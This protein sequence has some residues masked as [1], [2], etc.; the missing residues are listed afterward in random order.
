MENLD[1]KTI[2]TVAQ[3][4]FTALIGLFGWFIR[5]TLSRIEKDIEKN[6]A[7]ICQLEALKTDLTLLKKDIEFVNHEV[8]NI[9]TIGEDIA[10]LKRDQKSIWGRVDELRIKFDAIGT[11]LMSPNRR[12]K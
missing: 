3:S 11:V 9:R 7:Q 4:V 10:V 2:L 8:R 1:S 12:G 5:R 6:T